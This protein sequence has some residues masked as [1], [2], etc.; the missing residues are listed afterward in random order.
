MSLTVFHHPLFLKDT[1]YFPFLFSV[2]KRIES[3]ESGDDEGKKH[4]VCIVTD[5]SQQ[6][7][8]DEQNGETSAG[9]L[10]L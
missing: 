1:N 3:E 5:L 10:F 6:S 9:K 2:D 8:R 4:A 7:L